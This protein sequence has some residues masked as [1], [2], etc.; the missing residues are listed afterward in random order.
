MALPF[1]QV[2]V[3]WP[4]RKHPAFASALALLGVALAAESKTK[5][6]LIAMMASRLH[7]YLFIIASCLV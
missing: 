5:E 7:V 2:R 1:L 6:W 3:I 4:L